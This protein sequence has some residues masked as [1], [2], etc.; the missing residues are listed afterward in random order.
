MVV[1]CITLNH[2]TG[3]VKTNESDVSELTN[4]KVSLDKVFVNDM[5]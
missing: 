2:V 4:L 3:V 1:L 5:D